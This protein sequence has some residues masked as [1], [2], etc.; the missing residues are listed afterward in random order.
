M[1][2]IADKIKVLLQQCSVVYIK[3]I[4]VIEDFQTF[5]RLLA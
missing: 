4:V 2:Y 3:K 5:F 1:L